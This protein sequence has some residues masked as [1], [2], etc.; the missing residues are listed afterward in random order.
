[1]DPKDRILMAKAA[2]AIKQLEADNKTL[3]T[4]LEGLEKT[5]SFAQNLSKQLESAKVVLQMVVDGE[6][7]PGD[8]LEKFGEVCNLDGTQ[9]EELLRK[10]DVEKVGHI[11]GDSFSS[12]ADPLVSYLLGTR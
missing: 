3:R 9:V 8:A 12:E 7:D 6:T 2:Q 5:A 1:M 4:K 11:K 10:Q